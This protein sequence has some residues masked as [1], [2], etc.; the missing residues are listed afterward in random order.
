MPITKGLDLDV[1]DRQDRYSDFGTTNNAK[2]QAALS[3]GQFLTFRGTASTG[4]R[5]PTLFN[6]YTP[7]FLAASTGGTMGAGNPDCVNAGPLRPRTAP[8]TPATCN[9]QGLGLYGGNTNLTPETSQNFD[10]GVVIH[11]RSRIWALRWTIYRILLKN[12]IQ[13]V[14]ASGHLRQSHHVPEPIRD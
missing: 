5:A 9:T 1:S 14:P 3:A 6:L 4:F 11:R 7:N 2:I 13:P 10:L 12:T 8:F